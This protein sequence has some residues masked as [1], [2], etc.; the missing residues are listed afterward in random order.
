MRIDYLAGHEST[1]ISRLV[2]CP[3]CRRLIAARRAKAKA[4]FA[5]VLA[6]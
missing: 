3:D 6:S 1:Q 2:N 5:K 4:T